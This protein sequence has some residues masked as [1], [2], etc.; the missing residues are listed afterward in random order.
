MNVRFLAVSHSKAAVLVRQQRTFIVD[1]GR[2]A[3]GRIEPLAGKATNGR[4]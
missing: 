1:A 3:Q 2:T 4:S